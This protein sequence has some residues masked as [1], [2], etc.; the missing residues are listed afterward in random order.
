MT[1]VTVAGSNLKD[2]VVAEINSLG[3]A[4]YLIESKGGSID[5][6]L[7]KRFEAI[8]D[9]NRVAPFSRE[10]VTIDG[11]AAG[12]STGDIRTIQQIANVKAVEGSLDASGRAPSRSTAPCRAPSSA[13]R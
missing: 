1:L 13:G 7:V 2:Y 5:P 10:P 12:L 4:D 11:K 8:K 9:V 6:A 3:S